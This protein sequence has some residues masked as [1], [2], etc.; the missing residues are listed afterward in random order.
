MINIIEAKDK[1]KQNNPFYFGPLINYTIGQII[2]AL[3]DQTVASGD[4]TDTL[5]DAI[6]DTWAKPAARTMGAN[7][8]NLL[9]GA[10]D[11]YEGRSNSDGTH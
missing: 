9:N 8:V 10:L 1:L 2:Q 7:I 6:N 4:F 3:R 11:V 5:V